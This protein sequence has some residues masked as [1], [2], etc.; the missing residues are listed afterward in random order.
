M[1]SAIVVRMATRIFYYGGVSHIKLL[2]F[3][4]YGV[5]IGMNT[6]VFMRVCV[7]LIL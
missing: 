2:L 7:G 3:G 6:A 5:M 1:L 4:F